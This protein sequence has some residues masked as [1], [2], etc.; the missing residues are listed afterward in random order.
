[1][2]GITLCPCAPITCVTVPSPCAPVPCPGVG[3]CHSLGQCCHP[4]HLHP[5]EISALF[6][7]SQPLC[8]AAWPFPSAFAV[9]DLHGKARTSPAP[10]YQFI[11][12]LKINL[13]LLLT[14]IAQRQ[15]NN[16]YT[17]SL[18]VSPLLVEL[19]MDRGSHQD[20]LLTA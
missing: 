11:I 17:C 6:Q 20:C 15:K 5:R 9:L 3:Q 7:P 2:L 4:A 12:R 10:R 19:L 8:R 18:F 13:R 1:M 14:S 16:S